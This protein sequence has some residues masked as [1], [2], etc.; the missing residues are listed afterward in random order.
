MARILL[1]NV[2]KRYG[3][4]KELAVDNFNMDI[5]D[6][7]FLVFL[8]PSGCGKSTTLR[9]VAGLEDISEGEIYIGD[10]LVNDYPPKDRDISMVFQNYAL[11]PNL[12][13]YENI[14]FGL[15]IRKMPKHEI[16][17]A[18]KRAADVLE[19]GNFLNRK[20]RELSGGQRQRVALGRAI[21]RSPQAFLM[22][23]P[24]SNLDAKLRV[25]MRA[26][27]IRLHRTIGVTTIYVTHDQIEAMTMGD[28]IVVMNKGVIQQVDTPEQIYHKPQ[29][30]FV[31]KFIGNQP[32]NFFEGTIEEINGYL[33]FSTQT[34]SIR[35]TDKQTK[36]FNQ[37]RGVSYNIIM[38]IRPEYMSFEKEMFDVYP[39][40]V[41]KG[42]LQFN[43]F[44][45]SDHYYHLDS[46]GRES[47]T[48]RAHPRF[49][50][51][52]GEEV[53]VAIDMEKVL[54]F[55]SKTEKLLTI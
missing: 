1:N 29:N 36:M 33:T 31:A 43:E 35:L 13:V 16:E 42:V 10:T 32:M 54:F 14:A 53:R 48:V 40:A 51:R 37:L 41:L 22:D 28:R 47:F 52:E 27:I 46:Q 6:Q 7:E 3:K 4:F 38:G 45:G 19:I 39:N 15:R 9:M 34:F 25:Q 24:L 23:E 26:E 44:I 18:V 8:G 50:Y 55:D 21:V 17:A 5:K 30:L 12:T 20:P 2:T 49:S 11:Y